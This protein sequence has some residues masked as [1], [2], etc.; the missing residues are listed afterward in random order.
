MVFHDPPPLLLA[1]AQRE[2]FEDSGVTAHEG[3]GWARIALDWLN[4]TWPS[5]E[6]RLLN[7][8]RAGG[9]ASK[10]ATCL[11]KNTP[12]LL[13]AD[14]VL[15]EFGVTAAQYHSPTSLMEVES[16]IRQL[17]A[18][19][20]RPAL[21]MVQF[22][23]WCRGRGTMEL[24]A[25]GNVES[26]PVSIA[27]LL[28]HTVPSDTE[29]MKLAQHYDIPLV[30]TVDFLWPEIFPNVSLAYARTGTSP[31]E[32]RM[33][34]PPLQLRRCFTDGT[35]PSIEGT[36]TFGALVSYGLHLALHES[37]HHYKGPHRPGNITTTRSSP[38]PAP[39]LT[40]Q[41]R[42]GGSEC[43]RFVQS[44]GRSN[45]SAI[46]DHELPQI[47]AQWPPVVSSEGFDYVDVITNL[48][49]KPRWKPGVV[50]TMPG[51]YVELELDL[52]GAWAD[53]KEHQ[54]SGEHKTAFEL[55]LAYLQ[56]YTHM[57]QA[58]VTC[59]GGCSCGHE[60]IDAHTTTTGSSVTAGTTLELFTTTGAVDA[61][62]GVMCTVRIEVLT[63]TSSGEHNFK[64]TAVNLHRR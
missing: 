28:E 64:L 1:E 62:Q 34:R 47:L 33:A 29:F 41:T 38:V 48:D 13:E 43:W 4:H 36:R 35:H 52:F 15:L 8:A 50:A 26:P 30:S 55:E 17:M 20:R 22:V 31:P 23:E 11:S 58:A 60:V 61:A 9:G 18:L 40:K 46:P 21:M 56:S 32:E 3:A 42:L 45:F 24:C 25:K 51:S 10:F 39:L 37:L 63:A 12:M 19:K 5:S 59:S 7:A 53:S 44:L 49:G 27:S 6:H 57:G 16:I 54:Q 14:L 2:Y